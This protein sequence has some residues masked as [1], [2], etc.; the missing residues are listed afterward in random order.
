[1]WPSVNPKPSPKF[2]TAEYKREPLITGHKSREVVHSDN[3]ENHEQRVSCVAVIIAMFG[4]LVVIVKKMALIGTA[5][6]GTPS[7]R[8]TNT[9]SCPRGCCI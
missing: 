4:L 3:P 1:M 8:T 7:P 5:A 9:A 6:N 2:L